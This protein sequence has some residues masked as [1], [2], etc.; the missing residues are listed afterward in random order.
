MAT[1]KLPEFTQKVIVSV[2]EE[3]LNDIR[4]E[5]EEWMKKLEFATLQKIV[6]KFPAFKDWLKTLRE[7]LT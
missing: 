6:L 3:V 1:F 4:E 2:G 7:E 5:P